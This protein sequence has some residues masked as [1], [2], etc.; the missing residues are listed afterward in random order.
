[1]AQRPA[2]AMTGR[3]VPRGAVRPLLAAVLAA[4]VASALA[5][6]WANAHLPEQEEVIIEGHTFV[7]DVA[8]D[9]EERTRGLSGRA[10][11]PENG[12]MIF[13]FPDSDI[14]SFWMYDTLVDL[15][16]IYLDDFGRVTAMHRMPVEPPR[17]EGE[18]EWDYT[19]RLT[20]YS[21]RTRARFA[22]ELAPGWLDRLDLK[23]Q[24]KIEL[25]L[26]RL[27]ARAR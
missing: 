1:M 5:G 2:T 23:V 18:S 25:D 20:H 10:S 27:K 19:D 21:S 12:G 17:R 15:E 26:E 4:I 11:L 24:D 9:A 13:I 8:D 14:R 22:I 7:L 6:C 3:S 16:I